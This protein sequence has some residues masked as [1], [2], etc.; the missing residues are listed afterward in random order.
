MAAD[1]VRE[2]ID[3]ID[4]INDDIKSVDILIHSAGGDALTAWKLMVGAA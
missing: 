2:M 3:Q 4:A 1:A